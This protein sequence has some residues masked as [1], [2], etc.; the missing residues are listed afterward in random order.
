MS[1]PEY[2]EEVIIDSNSVPIVLSIWK[3][4]REDPS[5]IFFPGT[6]THP[7]FYEEFLN[8]LSLNGFNVIGVH[9]VCHG[10]SPRVK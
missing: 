1:I 9:L 4:K 3:S 8:L 6:M 2:Y 7:L 10:K 5:I